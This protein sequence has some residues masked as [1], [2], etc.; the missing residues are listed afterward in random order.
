MEQISE[1][2]DKNILSEELSQK[3]FVRSAN[4]GGNE[5]YIIT[6]HDSPNVMKEIGRLREITFR[7]AG[8][9]TGKPIDIDEFD[10]ADA[11]YK[12]LIVWNPEDRE[13]VGGYRYIKCREAP[14]K[15]GVVQLA[16]TELFEF[17]QL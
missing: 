3:R 14:L 12:Q 8:G 4:N 5:I 9:G 13:I 15:D 16:T 6:H 1:A 7:A 17:S 11:P 10:T 2:I